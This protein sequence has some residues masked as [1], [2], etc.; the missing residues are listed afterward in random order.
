[1]LRLGMYLDDVDVV[2][3]REAV[4]VQRQLV[5]GRSE[6]PSLHQA[7]DSWERGKWRA[8]GVP[9]DHIDNSWG[10]L[11]SLRLLMRLPQPNNKNA[12]APLPNE[13]LLLRRGLRFVTAVRESARQSIQT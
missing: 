7:A 11:H 4:R 2:V 9:E 1:M 3:P 12:L 6:M 10:K 5:E 8:L 13:Y